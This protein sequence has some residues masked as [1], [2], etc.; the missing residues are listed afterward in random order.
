MATVIIIGA[1]ISGLATA[2]WLKQQGRHTIVMDKSYRPGGAI[3]SYKLGCYLYETG[4]NTFLDNVQEMM[5]LCKELKLHN[6]IF[7][8]SM[9]DNDRYIYYNGKLNKIVPGPAFLKS[10]LLSRETKW[11]MATEAFR[12][13]NRSKQDESLGSFIRR[14]FGDDLLKNLVTPFISGVYAG[15]PD[16]LSLR[17]TFPLLYDLE[18]Q[19]GSVIRGMFLKMLFKKKDLTPR[20]KKLRT[21]NMCSFDEGMRVLIEA[22]CEEVD[23]LKL[24]RGVKEIKKN[25]D[26]TFTVF[27]DRDEVITGDAVVL[28][29]SS[30]SV[31][32]IAGQFFPQTSKYLQS[33]PYNR[34][35]VVGLGYKREAVQHECTGFGFLVPRNQNIRIL[36]CLFS[37]SLF[38]LRAPRGEMAF[39]VFIGGG[40]DQQAFDMTDDELYALARK[41]L[42][43]S[44]GASG[45]P[46]YKT[47]VRWEKAIPQYPIGHLEEIAKVEAECRQTPGLFLA[48]NYLDGVSTNDCVYRAKQVSEE[49]K[50]Y[51]KS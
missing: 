46:E 29:T 3:H 30:Y 2:H 33:I 5:D 11:K 43:T 15:D 24:S 36:G 42:E 35:A 7:K 10:E 16:K 6:E 50:N 20:K 21:K 14:R 25:A 47:L 51:L 13:G 45:E 27:A 40:L 17:S 9:R 31:P 18:R 22:M 4:P 44:I 49:I 34:L 19:Y 12:G 32:E 8:V 1:G 39:T 41:D 48:G 37:S 26:G 38:P 23:D 28:A